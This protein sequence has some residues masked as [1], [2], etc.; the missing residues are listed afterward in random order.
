MTYADNR[1]TILTPLPIANYPQMH[2]SPTPPPGAKEGDFWFN[3]SPLV[4]L[5]YIYDSGS[6]K[7]V[8]HRG[9]KMTVSPAQPTGPAVDGDFWFD[10]VTKKLHVMAL[11]VWQ[12][13]A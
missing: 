7:P 8:E 13:V 6:F 3:N 2:A 5:L 1:P 4:H 10:P 9:P 12:E 11:L